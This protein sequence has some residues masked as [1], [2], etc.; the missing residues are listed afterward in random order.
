M[1]CVLHFVACKVGWDGLTALSTA[2]LMAIAIVAAL[3]TR[4]QIK[5][6]RKEAKIKHLIDLVDQFE[7]DPWAT[8]RR[9]L[10]RLRVHDGKLNPLT[11]DDPPDEL[12]DILNFFEHMGYL[13]DGGYLD[14]VGVSVEFHFWIFHVWADAASLVEYEQAES[15]VYYEYVTKMV[16]RLV[17]L[18][19]KRL[20]GFKFPTT[21]DVVDFYEGEA[22]LSTHGPIPRQK[23]KRKLPS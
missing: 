19:R 8:Q 2:A 16:S 5:D 21:A 18:E 12:H 14:I 17:E 6:F 20:P 23:R 1:S 3:Y 4:D 9:Q 7:R 10:G 13:L 15:P 22:H 11:L